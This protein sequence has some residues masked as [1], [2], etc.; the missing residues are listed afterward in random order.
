MFQ[1]WEKGHY[2]CEC[3][4][5]KNNQK[6][7]YGSSSN[8][9][10]MVGEIIAMVSEMRITMIIELHMEAAANASDWWLDSGATVQLC[11]ENAQFKN[12][13]KSTDGQ[14]NEMGNNNAT[15][16]LR[17]WNIEL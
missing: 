10:N 15:K 9:T 12:Y 8:T 7:E 13:V 17:K 4:F 14:E 1:L 11:N 6:K 5:L 16:V 3:R 2:I